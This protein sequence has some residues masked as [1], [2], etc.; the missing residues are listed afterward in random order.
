MLTPNRD[1]MQQ[2]REALRGK[3][4]IAIGGLVIYIVIVTLPGFIPILGMIATIV[5]A[6]PMVIGVCVFTLTISRKQEPNISQLFVGFSNFTNALVGYLLMAVFVLL[7]MLLLIIPGIIA[8]FSYAL[9]FFILAEN[10]SI[11]GRDA[12]RQSK[13]MMD[14]KKGKLFCLYCRFIGWAILCLFTLGIG[15]LWLGPYMAVSFAR[16]YDD[17]KAEYQLATTGNP[18]QQ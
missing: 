6:G 5:I 16:F 9:T 15:F 11:S 14:G 18:V 12:I 8:A 4:P 7:W 3:W 1:L 13:Q 17:V 2:A 10:S